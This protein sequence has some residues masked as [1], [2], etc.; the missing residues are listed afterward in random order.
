MVGF[1][2]VCNVEFRRS[3]HDGPRAGVVAVGRSD[4]NVRNFGQT[5][6]VVTESMHTLCVPVGLN[7]TI[8]FVN[9]CFLFC[10]LYFKSCLR[11]RRPS[12]TIISRQVITPY[13][14][15]LKK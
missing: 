4:K 5:R 2:N 11:P 12:I 3:D 10:Q 9:D 7:P 13:L 1:F 14:G 8:D 6:L 15:F